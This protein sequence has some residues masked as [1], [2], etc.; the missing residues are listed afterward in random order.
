MTTVMRHV[1]TCDDYLSLPE[2]GPF[3]YEVFDGER[4]MT[5]SLTTEKRDRKEKFSLYE[6][7]GVPEYWMVDLETETFQVFLL[8][9]RASVS[10]GEFRGEAPLES[11]P[12]GPIV[13][14]SGDLY[15]LIRPGP[16]E[17]IPGYPRPVL[18]PDKRDQRPR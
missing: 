17:W 15:R 5:L 13:S 8:K 9:E 18:P 12:S 2:E 10:W 4:Y 7:F 11:P 3:H 14:R 1:L 6:R 16:R